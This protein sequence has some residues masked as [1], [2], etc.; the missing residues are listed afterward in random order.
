M[1]ALWVLIPLLV[2]VSLPA[3]IATP[4]AIIAQENTFWKAYAGGNAE[5]LLKLLL[6]D[7]INV[8]EQIWT[9]DQVL[10]FV[11][12]TSPSSVRISPPSC[13]TLQRAPPA[14]PAWSPATQT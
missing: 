5:D 10:A 1:R 9:G 4:E 2:A 8:E 7:F 13:T 3:Q 11:I 14:G 6:P 12:P